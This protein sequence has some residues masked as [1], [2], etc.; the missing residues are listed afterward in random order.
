MNIP[1]VHK[2]FILSIAIAAFIFWDNIK[3]VYL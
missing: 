1:K 3:K 2:I